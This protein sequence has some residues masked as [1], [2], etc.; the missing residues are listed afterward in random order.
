MVYVLYFLAE[1]AVFSVRQC[2]CCYSCVVIVV[3]C[4][5]KIE[6]FSYFLN[7]TNGTKSRKASHMFHVSFKVQYS[8]TEYAREGMKVWEQGRNE[9]VGRQCAQTCPSLLIPNFRKG[10]GGLK[11]PQFLEGRSLGKCRW[12]FQGLQFLHKK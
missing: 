3:I 1:D 4:S 2:G 6:L 11:G 12:P 5:S 10:E 8:S 9:K 7:C